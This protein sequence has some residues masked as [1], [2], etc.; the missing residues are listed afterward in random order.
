[1][2][3]PPRFGPTPDTDLLSDPS[4]VLDSHD[5]PLQR[6]IS[7][8]VPQGELAFLIETIF[9]NQKVAG[10]VDRLRGSDLQTF[11]DVMDEVWRHTLP[12][13]GHWL[14]GFYSNLLRSVGHVGIG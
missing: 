5:Q 3:D 14:I 12:S 6:L 7:R 2:T 9:S 13:S 1:M 8:A 11:I 4:I 10:V